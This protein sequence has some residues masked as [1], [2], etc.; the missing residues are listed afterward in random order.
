MRHKETH[1][2]NMP[3]YAN[4]IIEFA[5]GVLSDKLKKRVI[6]RSSLYVLVLI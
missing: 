6:V 5:M 4:K 2:I 1:F 3:A